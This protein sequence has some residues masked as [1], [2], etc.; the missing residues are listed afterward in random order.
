[1]VPMADKEAGKPVNQMRDELANKYNF[2]G[3]DEPTIKAVED[4]YAAKEVVS[5]KINE[6]FD[7]VP[8][9]LLKLLEMDTGNLWATIQD[10]NFADSESFISDPDLDPSH[11]PGIFDIFSSLV[12]FETNTHTDWLEH[13]DLYNTMTE[14]FISIAEKS[15]VDSRYCLL[16]RTIRHAFDSHIS[17]MDIRKAR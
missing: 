4:V 14:L 11:L 16:G 2:G 15:R 8:F 3:V 1:M 10:I 12:T 9:P 5:A 17:S 13:P 7:T 6:Q